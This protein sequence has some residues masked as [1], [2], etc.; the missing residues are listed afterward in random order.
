MANHGYHFQ[1][2]K[3]LAQINTNDTIHRFDDCCFVEALIN[4]SANVKIGFTHLS[5]AASIP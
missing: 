1:Q 5:E 4:D 2:F 3:L